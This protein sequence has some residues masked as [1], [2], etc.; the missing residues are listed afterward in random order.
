[1]G[2]NLTFQYTGTTCSVLKRARLT[3]RSLHGGPLRV[4]FG[5]FGLHLAGGLLV[6]MVSVF[7]LSHLC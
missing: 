3:C 4:C 5:A 6:G 1:M 2:T 7:D